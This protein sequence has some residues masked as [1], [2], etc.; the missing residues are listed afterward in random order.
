MPRY[1]F[2]VE[3][4]ET[5]FEDQ[6][7]AVYAD[8]EAAVRGAKCLAEDLLEHGTRVRWSRPHRPHEARNKIA[9][10]TIRPPNERL[11]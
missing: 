5:R 10:L 2:E 11:Q 9:V 7:G 1:Y 3:N 8:D 6:N 4:E